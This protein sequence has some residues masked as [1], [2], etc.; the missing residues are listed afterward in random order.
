MSEDITAQLIDQALLRGSSEG[1]HWTPDKLLTELVTQGQRVGIVPNVMQILEHL[2]HLVR[3]GALAIAP[4]GMRDSF[5]FSHPDGGFSTYNVPRMI[6]TARGRK[7]LE[8]TEAS[9]HNRPRYLK[10]IRDRIPSP[11]PIIIAYI[12]ESIGAWEAGLYRSAVVMTGC[13]CERL[14]LLLASA[15]VRAK[16]VPWSDRL[17][18]L[19]KKATGIS[20]IY[21]EVRDALLDLAGSKKFSGELGDA[22]DRKLSSIFDHVRIQRNQAGHP[23]GEEVLAEDAEAGLLM[24]PGFYAYADKLITE[25]GTL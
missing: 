23:T 5:R 2:A 14:I 4:P 15:L 10:S 8:R 22:L 6:V 1:P 12:E 19:S 11:D 7:L 9:P 13:A 25:L 3:L 21:D 20:E 18:K 24:F 17:A 16:H